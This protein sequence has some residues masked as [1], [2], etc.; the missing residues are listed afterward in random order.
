MAELQKA[1]VLLEECDRLANQDHSL[2]RVCQKLARKIKA[3][4]A[5]LEKHADQDD[6]EGSSS[7]IPYLSGVLEVVK[8]SNDVQE[9]ICDFKK[10]GITVDV[11][12]D[13]GKTWKKVIARNPQSLHL[14]WAGKGQ[15]GTKDVVKKA[16]R[17]SA[18]AKRYCEFSPPSI[19]CVFCNG[20]T[21]ELAK[22]LESINVQVIG[23]RIPVSEEVLERLN[24]VLIQ[25]SDSSDSD[26]LFEKARKQLA[27]SAAQNDQVCMIG[28]I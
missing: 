28:H 2:K 24:S 25:D 16:E 23:D 15:Y 14:I 19:V 9:V 10:Y 21:Y 27:I 6:F 5:F 22:E 11:V 13:G 18:A 26:D 1:Q 7:N 12:C 8:E 17:Y 4:V 20:V 3:D